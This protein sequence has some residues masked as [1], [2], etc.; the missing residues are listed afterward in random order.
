AIEAEFV[1]N[2]KNQ[3]YK[4]G[5]QSFSLKAKGVEVNTTQFVS[6]VYISST[7][8]LPPG[9]QR[10]DKVSGISLKFSSPASGN[11]LVSVTRDIYY[12]DPNRAPTKDQ[13]YKMLIS[14]YGN[15]SL[16]E[17]S[18]GIKTI[19]FARSA[20][21][22]VKCVGILDCTV[23]MPLYD[24][25]NFQGG[26]FSVG[27]KADYLLRITVDRNNSDMS[28]TKVGAIHIG[29]FDKAVAERAAQADIA[30]LVEKAN[31][32]AATAPAV[33]LPKF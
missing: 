27:N 3:K 9:T 13:I 33:A 21:R 14:K 5:T 20:G 1:Q 12:S 30:A 22:Y 28:G 31:E 19:A 8:F 2:D 32:V 7:W 23:S 15:A 18:D 24:L 26:G 16:E 17:W 10:P 6:S 11:K 4:I 25:S 29:L